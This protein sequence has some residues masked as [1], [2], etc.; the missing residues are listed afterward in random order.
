M[1]KKKFIQNKMVSNLP[2]FYN[3]VVYVKNNPKVKL[4]NTSVYYTG[5]RITKDNYFPEQPRI[6]Y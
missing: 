2:I 4:I 6:F 1:K 3:F 5:L